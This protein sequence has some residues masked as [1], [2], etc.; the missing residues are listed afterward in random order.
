MMNV[1]KSF[2]V[3]IL[4]CPIVIFAQNTRDTIVTKSADS[5]SKSTTKSVTT[6]DSA[7]LKNDA[8]ASSKTVDTKSIVIKDSTDTAK[9]TGTIIEE[10]EEQ[11]ILDGGEESLIPTAVEKVQ[12][13]VATPDTLKDSSTV[14]S[15]VNK[16]DSLHDSASVAPL[17]QYVSPVFVPKEEQIPMHVEKT[18]SIN[19][20]NN[21][22]EYRSP[23]IAILLSLLIPGTGQAYAHNYLK[24]GIFGAV[25]AALITVGVIS[26]YQGSK[27]WDD[28]RSYADKHYSVEQ[29]NEYYSNLAAHFSDTIIQQIFE[30]DSNPSSFLE[31]ADAKKKD[32]DF[33]DN[34][35]YELSPY[36]QGWDDVT[37]HFNSEF[38]IENP[39]VD[40]G[41]YVKVE[42]ADSSYLVYFI[43]NDGDTVPKESQYGFSDNQ[44]H[45]NKQISEANQKYRLS[46]NF[47]TLLLVNHLASAV[48]AAITA[49][50]HNDKLLGKNTVWQKFNINELVVTTPVGVA[51]G[52]A[53][54]VRF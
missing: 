45:Y 24:T 42:V 18:Q 31:Y 28:A 19:F 14:P 15:I 26:R 17:Q 35:R 29:F 44:K 37:P 16:S 50:A 10:T 23:K 13:V 33:Y 1:S 46:K 7:I 2:I 11:L 39:T 54:D 48:D 25:E 21:F 20:A 51:N 5:L 43:N 32:D 6:P 34:I 38:E 30:P 49:K 36:I 40:N 8:L 53:L 47:F 41:S 12:P 22:K 3:M 4:I 9:K 52:L 27:K